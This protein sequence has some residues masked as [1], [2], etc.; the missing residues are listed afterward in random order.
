MWVDGRAQTAFPF[1]EEHCRTEDRS[2]GGR[3]WDGLGGLGGAGTA[4][5]LDGAVTQVCTRDRPAQSRVWTASGLCVV[6]DG[7]RAHLWL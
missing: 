1:T 2:V 6:L 7:A 5:T 3:G 4:G